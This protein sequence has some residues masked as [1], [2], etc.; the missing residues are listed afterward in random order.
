MHICCPDGWARCRYGTA[1]EKMEQTL[2]RYIKIYESIRKP[3]MLSSNFFSKDSGLIW[4]KNLHLISLYEMK[5]C[6]M[7]KGLWFQ[8]FLLSFFSLESIYDHIG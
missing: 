3:E 6:V 2:T 7:L 8:M 4:D 1:N 5:I